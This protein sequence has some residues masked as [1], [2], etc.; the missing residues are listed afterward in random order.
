MRQVVTMAVL[1]IALSLTTVEGQSGSAQPSTAPPAQTQSASTD[2]V[3]KDA[4][5]KARHGR[6]LTLAEITE[7]TAAEQR[8][9]E[10]YDDE[11]SAPP[12][13]APAKAPAP[14]PVIPTVQAVPPGPPQKHLTGSEFALIH[15]G[16]TAKEVLNVLGPPSSRVVVPDDDD[17]LRETL[18]YWVKGAPAATVRLDNG[19]VVEIETK[20]N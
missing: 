2:S 9:I 3:A 16:S 11:D 12:S 19:R 17:H 4:K 1:G 5:P 15:V 20:P 8:A 10:G 14:A 6:P 7:G 13:A 18:Q